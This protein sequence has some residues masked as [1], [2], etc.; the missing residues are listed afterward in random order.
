MREKECWI[1][2]IHGLWSC[3]RFGKLVA[4]PD[5]RALFPASFPPRTVPVGTL[6]DDFSATPCGH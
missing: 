4:E 1:F 3:P 5:E 2:T 6:V